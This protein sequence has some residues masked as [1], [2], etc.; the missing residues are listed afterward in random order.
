MGPQIATQLHK[1][2]LYE[3]KIKKVVH[4]LLCKSTILEL[5]FKFGRMF[6]T[7]KQTVV[8]DS[9]QSDHPYKEGNIAFSD[10]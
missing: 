2:I 5:N 3:V 6:A 1:E 9:G 7:M 4:C 10:F 8:T